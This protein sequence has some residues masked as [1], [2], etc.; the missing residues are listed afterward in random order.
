LSEV[1]AALLTRSVTSPE[2]DESLRTAY[3]AA[4]AALR[5]QD[6]TLANLRNRATALAAS[7]TLLASLATAV[8]LSNGGRAELPHWAGYPMIGLFLGVGVLVTLIVWPARNFAFGPDANEI[9]M[10]R[11]NGSSTNQIKWNRYAAS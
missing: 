6:V 5:Q 3:E 8:G 4:A 10:L 9:L 7:T 1:V 11:R 2:S